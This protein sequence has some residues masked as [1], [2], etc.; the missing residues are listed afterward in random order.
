MGV[1]KGTWDEHW[2]RS[3]SSLFEKAVNQYRKVT[4]RHVARVNSRYFRSSGSFLECGAG[5]G[6]ASVMMTQNP[7]QMGAVDFSMQPLSECRMHGRYG[8]FVQADIVQLPFKNNSI[9][10]I[11]NVGVME[12][13]TEGELVAVMREFNRVLSNDGYCVLFWPS[14]LAPSHV[15]FHSLEWLLRRLG[16]RKQFFPPACSM[17]V[18]P[19]TARK[20][21]RIAGFAQTKSHLPLDLTHWAIVGRKQTPPATP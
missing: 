14:A 20:L 13:F 1:E 4:A 6:Q 9:D 11:W 19:R 10:G 16:V 2:A 5:T 15:V 21:L 17:I 7:S 3:T 8:F 18:H 12:H